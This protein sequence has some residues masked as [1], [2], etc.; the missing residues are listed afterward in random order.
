MHLQVIHSYITHSI[1]ITDILFLKFEY[2]EL[3]LFAALLDLSLHLQ[4]SIL[5]L[6]ERRCGIIYL[7]EKRYFILSNLQQQ[8]CLYTSDGRDY[9]HSRKYFLGTW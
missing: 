3:I 6:V 7:K 9:P 8:I 4:I 5:T 2:Y 1:Y